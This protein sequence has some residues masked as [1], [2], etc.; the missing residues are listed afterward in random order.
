MQGQITTHGVI[1]KYISPPLTNNLARAIQISNWCAKEIGIYNE[2]GSIVAEKDVDFVRSITVR[3]VFVNE[4]DAMK[5]ILT[6]C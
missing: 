4:S 6:W 1:F 3:Y 2:M 5:F